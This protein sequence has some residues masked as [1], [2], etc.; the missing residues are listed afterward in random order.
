M[1]TRTI[2]QVKIYFLVMNGVYDN[3]EYGS[4]TVVSTSKD[5]LHGYYE[6]QLLPYEERFRDDCGM[7][8]SFRQGPLYDFNPLSS[9]E[10][11][12]HGH[13]MKEEW[14]TMEELDNV[15]HRYNFIEE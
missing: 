14:L 1:E 4:I 8:R 15:K 13:G 11:N 5:R 7:Y 3:A 12:W 10:P 6:S 2:T 9:F